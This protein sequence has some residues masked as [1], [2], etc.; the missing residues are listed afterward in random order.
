MLEQTTTL[1]LERIYLY[2]HILLNI[3]LSSPLPLTW[4]LTELHSQLDHHDHT[5]DI[6]PSMALHI[7]S[8][9]S[10]YTMHIDKKKWDRSIIKHDIPFTIKSDLATSSSLDLGRAQ[11][12]IV[13]WYWYTVT[14]PYSGISIQWNY[15]TVLL[16]NS[17]T[18]IH[19]LVLSY[20]LC[21]YHTLM[22]SKI[23]TV[24]H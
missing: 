7:S 9:S 22:L 18:A 19:I 6:V 24:T 13:H 2:T 11:P 12:R 23:D 17:G 14:L 5:V 15:H 16:S 4:Q 21:H 3:S 1:P 20:G 8:I 10:S